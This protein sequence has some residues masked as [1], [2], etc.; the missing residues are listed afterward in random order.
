MCKRTD[1]CTY[2]SVNALQA[3]AQSDV[4]PFSIVFDHFLY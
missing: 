2:L 3:D 4:F 1:I